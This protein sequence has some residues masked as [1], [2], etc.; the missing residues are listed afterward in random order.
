MWIK[1][2]DEQTREKAAGRR[3]LL[4]V[5]GHASHFTFSFLDYARKH[6]IHVLCYPSHGT[7]VFQ[8]LDVVVFSVLKRE[9]TTARTNFERK[10][11]KVKKTNFL[12]VYGEAHVK[13]LTPDL[14][15]AAFKKA[16]VVPFNRSIVTQEMM[17]PSL[18]SSSR[19]T[20]P[21]QPPSP[22]RAIT[23]LLI[24]KVA[25]HA[26]TRSASDVPPSPM[27]T[28]ATA[29][30]P[31]PI[32]DNPPRTPNTPRTPRTP[33][34]PDSGVIR[35][36]TT[37][38]AAYLVS[39]TPIPTDAVRPRYHTITISPMKRRRSHILDR[40]PS[41]AHEGELQGLLRQAY[42]RENHL[43]QVIL[44][45]QAANVLNGLFI[46]RVQERLEGQEEKEGR[47]SK[48]RKLLGNGLPKLLT[49]DDVFM[50]VADCEAEQE[51]E[52]D[53]QAKRKEDVERY[54]GA[55]AAWKILEKERDERV[56]AQRE[57]YRE[58]K[59]RWDIEK[60][61]ATQQGR[62]VAMARPVLGRIEPKPGGKPVHPNRRKRVAPAA[63]EE[64]SEQEER[65]VGD[66][67][68]V[69]DSDSD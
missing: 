36:L 2:F 40:E 62:K 27:T 33:R 59:E 16:G 29:P 8:G 24:N 22:I 31:L 61:E 46:D 4:L 32:S 26:K 17:A 10:G 47:P 42:E 35:V 63:G 39:P 12:T 45:L 52:K 3:R 38:S 49:D 25:T 51:R 56:K 50:A 21:L 69:S 14:I 64:E 13:A 58:D 60:V 7:H 43:K 20:L 1:Q 15:R 19:G 6:N 11:K 30:A 55:L 57:R 68:S 28:P 37:T 9:W 67:E 5:D 41:T 54:E 53:L 18:E 23:Q 48:K 66:E 34:T 44:E 65:D